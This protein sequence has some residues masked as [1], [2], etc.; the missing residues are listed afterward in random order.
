MHALEVRAT[1]V[2]TDTLPLQF[3]VA[4]GPCVDR[5]SSNRASMAVEEPHCA[6]LAEY[7]PSVV[8]MS[9]YTV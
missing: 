2:S 1:G 7:C 4:L 8:Q 6:R 5:P 9:E 3:S